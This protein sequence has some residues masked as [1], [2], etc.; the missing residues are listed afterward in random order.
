[1]Q[2]ASNS[3]PQ[4]RK[5]TAEEVKLRQWHRPNNA[6]IM[7]I[8]KL[9]CMTTKQK[10]LK[11]QARNLCLAKRLDAE[12]GYRFH[13][14]PGHVCKEC[15]C[16]HT[17]GSGT[18][19]DFYGIGE[20]TGHYG[21]GWCKNHEK[22]SRRVPSVRYARECMEALQQLGRSTSNT[23]GDFIEIIKDEAEIFSMTDQVRK[24]SSLIL[25]QLEEFKK[26]C[27]EGSLT[28]KGKHGP[29]EASDVARIRLACEVAKTIA[30]I[31]K[32]EL[33]IA[34]KRMIPVEEVVMRIKNEMDLIRRFVPDPREQALLFEEYKGIWQAVVQKGT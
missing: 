1:M 4:R 6:Q 13:G 9:L 3:L 21:V 12:L 23:M 27:A 26:I 18:H 30:S 20:N 11:C 22:L 32:S 28:V 5:F 24:A 33:D 29:E 25:E 16:K 34:S 7:K 8:R 31:T 19:G 2:E 10:F 15:R 17:A 14:M